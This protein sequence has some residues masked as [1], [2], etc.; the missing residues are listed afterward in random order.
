MLVKILLFV[1]FV[2]FVFVLIDDYLG[3]EGGVIVYVE[4]MV[5]VMILILNV[6]VGVW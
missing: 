6:I 5:I 4:L 3:E 2:S 1:V